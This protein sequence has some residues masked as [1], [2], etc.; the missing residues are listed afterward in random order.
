[1]KSKNKAPTTSADTLQAL[2]KQEGAIRAT[3]LLYHLLALGLF[4]AAC[5][6]VVI[7]PWRGVLSWTL[8]LWVAGVFVALAALYAAVGYGFRT[9]RGW[10]GY[11]AGG[12]ALL[13]LSSLIINPAVQHPVVFSVALIRMF[14]LPVGIIITLYGAYL[15]LFAKGKM[16]L[17]PSYRA[18]ATGEVKTYTLSKLFLATGIVLVSV[19]SIKVLMVFTGQPN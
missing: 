12:L 18:S 1:M 10:S 6:G 2:A 11:A 19:Q 7:H 4:L 3:G 8:T 13:C 9:L 14:A 17:S 15:T 5:T 16:V